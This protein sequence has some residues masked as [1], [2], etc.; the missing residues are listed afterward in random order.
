MDK[1]ASLREILEQ[2]P[3]NAF[4]RYGLAMEYAGRGDTDA[5]L[6]EF[7]RLLA[8]HPDYTAG[9]FMAAQTLARTGRPADAKQRLIEGTACARRTGN[10]HA[11]REMQ[12]MLDEMEIPE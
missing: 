11:L 2:D 9:Y 1:I 5:A 3:K 12:A 10:Q 6:A 8:D 7:G 4:A